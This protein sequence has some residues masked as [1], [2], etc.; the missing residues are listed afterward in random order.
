[1]KFRQ[2][3]DHTYDSLVSDHAVLRNKKLPKYLENVFKYNETGLDIFVN[4]LPFV[5]ITQTIIAS[6]IFL[7]WMILSYNVLKSTTLKGW[8][9]A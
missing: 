8:S 7:Y 4:C 9:I 5:E 6:Q 1:M 2:K 3:K